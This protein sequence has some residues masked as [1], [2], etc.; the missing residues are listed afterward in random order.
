MLDRRGC[1]GGVVSGVINLES[2]GVGAS[3]WRP[4][5]WSL[6]IARNA[7]VPMAPACTNTSDMLKAS[8]G[9]GRRADSSTYGP[10][11]FSSVHSMRCTVE[12]S[13]Y[14]TDAIHASET[15]CLAGHVG[16]ELPNPRASYPIAVP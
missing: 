6:A 3:D 4:C 8:D 11:R 5:Q 9:L 13:P 14:G 12:K 2:S 1:E 15:D 7:Y 10:P 16:F